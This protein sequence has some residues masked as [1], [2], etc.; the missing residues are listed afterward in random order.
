MDWRQLYWSRVVKCVE[1]D[2]QTAICTRLWGTEWLANGSH[3]AGM[4]TGVGGWVVCIRRCSGMVEGGVFGGARIRCAGRARD[5]WL[6]CMMAV[7]KVCRFCSLDYW[8]AIRRI[9]F[10]IPCLVGDKEILWEE[11]ENMSGERD[12]VERIIQRYHKAI[13]TKW[14]FFFYCVYAQ[15]IKRSK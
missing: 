7:A 11:Q 14:D 8:M 5:E 12:G 2:C 3:W 6:V 9:P 4:A 10:H 15:P 1:E 13:A